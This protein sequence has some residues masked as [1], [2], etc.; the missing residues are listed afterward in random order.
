M[1]ARRKRSAGIDV[2]PGR[3]RLARAAARLSL[4]QVTRGDISRTALHLM[5]AGK[6]RPTL[7]TLKIIAE[8]TGQ[9]L[10]YFLTPTQADS[11]FADGPL[12]Q[13]LELAVAQGRYDDARHMT[14]RVLGVTSDRVLR[15]RV[16]LLGAQA[17]LQLASVE[18]AA[19]LLLEAR[20]VAESLGDK[21]MLAECLDWQAAAEHLLELPSALSLA[22][23][24]LTMANSL[25]PRPDRLLVRI[26]GRIGSIC[27][28]QH[29]WREAID[30]YQRAAE[31]GRGLLDM[32]RRAK[33]YN[34]LSI[35]NRRLGDLATA[36]EFAQKAV[37]IH[38][39]LS[40]GLSVGRA[41]TNLALALIR[42]G[43]VDE[44][45]RN[46]DHALTLFVAADHKRGRSHILLA[47]AELLI[48]TGDLAG[49]RAKAHAAMD[50]AQELNEQVTVSEAKQILATVAEALNDPKES[51][52]LFAESIELLRDLKLAPR[53]TAVHAAYAAA[54][55]Q[56]G[57][58]G[59][60][61]AQWRLA[62]ATT[63]P[64]AVKPL[65][66]QSSARDGSRGSRQSA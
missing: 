1:A 64:E 6:C 65:T 47:Q 29:K 60:A 32:S 50:L 55:E 37:S 38:E 31:V 21:W 49:A 42:Q 17:S 35:A 19:P 8:R 52:R 51:D 25:E 45:G 3:I 30:A 46:L 13:E 20:A 14:A 10:E 11:L 26:H 61:L 16:C 63:N 22:Q 40:D 23:Q 66:L 36:T 27:V 28:A 53:L 5:E 2:I 4:A 59:R 9:S 34:D 12:V 43:N 33:M 24:A 7:A 18:D 56:R 54:L 48:T 41:E 39:L 62:V 15:C 58:T 57:E 44:A